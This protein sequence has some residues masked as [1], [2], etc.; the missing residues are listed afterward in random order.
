[1]KKHRLGFMQLLDLLDSDTVD[2]NEG[3]VQMVMS[4]PANAYCDRNYPGQSLPKVH[5]HSLSCSTIIQDLMRW[6]S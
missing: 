3:Y 1:M 2:P 6:S 4:T 5:H